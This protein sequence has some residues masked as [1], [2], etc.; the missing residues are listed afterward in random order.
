MK[1]CSDSVSLLAVVFPAVVLDIVLIYALEFMVEDIGHGAR[2]SLRKRRRIDEYV[3]FLFF[4][5]S[6][7]LCLCIWLLCV[8]VHGKVF[9][10]MM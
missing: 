6:F 7:S 2:Y 10:P 5:L 9:M 3:F 1:S 8:R 4:S